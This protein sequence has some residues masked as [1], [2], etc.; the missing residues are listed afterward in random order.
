MTHAHRMVETNP[1][2]PA[3]DADALEEF[4]TPSA[5]AVPRLMVTAVM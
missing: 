3:V 2:G 4:C 1:S 5:L